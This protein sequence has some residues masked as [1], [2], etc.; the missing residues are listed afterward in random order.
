MNALDLAG[1]CAG[2]DD[3]A[4]DSQA[5]FRTALQALSHPGRILAL[6]AHAQVHAHGH[7]AAASL[8]LALLDGDTSLW[9]SPTLAAQ[10]AGQWL[11]FHTGCRLQ[12]AAD[13]AGFLWVA[14]NDTVPVLASLALGTLWAMRP[15]L[16]SG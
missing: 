6:P 7:C 4:L 15:H 16:R 3:E 1:L 13:Q 11:S 9:V 8:L 14:Q 10:K 5:V 2:F 12:P